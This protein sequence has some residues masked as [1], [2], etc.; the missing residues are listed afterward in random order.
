MYHLHLAHLT[1]Y[2]YRLPLSLNNIML[3]EEEEIRVTAG[4][5]VMG[6]IRIRKKEKAV[7]PPVLLVVV[8]LFYYVSF[9]K[10]EPPA[11]HDEKEEERKRE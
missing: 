9:T 3:L 7:T 8:L 4:E 6:W 1:H 5:T 2:Y 11:R 10:E